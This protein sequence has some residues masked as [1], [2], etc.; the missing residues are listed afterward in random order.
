M[1]G[2]LY[3][4]DNE[5]AFANLQNNDCQSI[6]RS[7]WNLKTWGCFLFSWRRA[8]RKIGR[9][10]RAA[11]FRPAVS[12]GAG[13]FSL[14]CG[15]EGK[16]RRQSQSWYW[17]LLKDLKVC[18]SPQLGSWILKHT[19]ALV[20]I[21]EAFGTID[22]QRDQQPVRAKVFFLSWNEAGCR[23]DSKAG[24]GS[25]FCLDKRMEVWITWFIWYDL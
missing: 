8:V 22:P 4:K 13:N 16:K 1:L 9:I 20:F 15:G 19:K 17:P 21:E 18:W 5:T 14:P 24:F 11:Y 12:T 2:Q 7:C 23:V 6:V 3:L 25:G 10:F